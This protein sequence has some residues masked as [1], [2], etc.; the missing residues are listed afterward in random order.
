METIITGPIRL[1]GRFLGFAARTLLAL[2][3][4]PFRRGGEVVRLFEQ[5]A[6]MSLPI[7]VGAGLSVGLA[8]WFQT[9]RL[10]AAH[11]AE[12]ALPSFLAVAVVVELGPLLAGVLTAG[13]VGA[14]LAAEMGV[15]TLNEEI[16]ARIVLGADPIPS[17]VA[18]RVVACVLALPL[19][20]VL[21]D[22]S[23]LAGALTAE[24]T[25][26]KLSTELFWR[27]SLVFLRLSDVVPAT[28]KTTV[29]GLVVGLVGCWVG[30]NAERSAEDVGRAATRGVVWTTLA[31]FAANVALVPFIPWA[32][33]LLGV[34]GL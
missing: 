28:L 10:L 2:P 9:H 19:L 29:F 13:R 3:V 5:M 18:P 12:A 14:G 31:V 24:A 17:L 30:L 25:A 1:A 22:A 33:G 11:G 23:A 34:G 27:Q 21:V 7:V 16:D 15:M 26:G 8:T 4:A 32:T 6:V 20:T